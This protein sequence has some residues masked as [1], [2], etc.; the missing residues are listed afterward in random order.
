[1]RILIEVTHPAHVHF[2]RIPFGEFKKRGHMVKV[3]AR[4]KDVTLKLLDVYKI[5]YQVLSKKGKSKFALLPELILHEGRLFGVL[6]EFKPDIILSIS[7]SFNVHIAKVLKIPSIV[8]SDTEHATL[9][10]NFTFPFADVICTP[11]SFLNDLGRKQIRYDGYH[12][13]AYLHPNYYVP[14]STVL[15]YL[16]VQENEKYVIMRF[17]SWGASHDIGHR[18]LSDKMK[19]EA[20][21]EFSKY[22]KVFISS[23]QD[24]PEDLRRYQIN[25][26]IEKIHDAMY[27]SAMYFG[28]SGTMASES[29]VLGTPAIN[30]STSA[31][32]IGV[33]ADMEKHGLMYV[34]PEEKKALS[35]GIELLKQKDISE[36]TKFRRKQMLSGKIDVIKFVVWLVEKYPESVSVLKKEPEYQYNFK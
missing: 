27:Y 10:N 12:D 5:P 25:I 26:P 1:M 21:R 34:L 16:G 31:Q 30:I 24:L 6:R 8:F 35:K 28:E 22:A 3:T 2:F 17:V 14:D 33:F 7:G 19:K 11:A 15:D 18:G 36:Q 29:A 32:F 9:S 23:E 13:L 20:I 4:D